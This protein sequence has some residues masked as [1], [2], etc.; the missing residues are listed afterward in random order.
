MF[1]FSHGLCLA[2]T[3]HTYK[4][5][6]AVCRRFRQ[7]HGCR[8]QQLRP[9]KSNYQLASAR[10]TPNEQCG[11]NSS[12]CFCRDFDNSHIIRFN[13]RTS[14]GREL[15]FITIEMTV[16]LSEKEIGIRGKCSSTA[17]PPKDTIKWII[18]HSKAW[19]E[20]NLFNSAGTNYF[21]FHV[22][23]RL[24]HSTLTCFGPY[25]CSGKWPHQIVYV[26]SDVARLSL[27]SGQCIEQ[28]RPLSVRFRIDTEHIYIRS[29]FDG[30]N[31][32]SSVAY[33]S[34]AWANSRFS[35]VCNICVVVSNGTHLAC[36]L[37][38]IIKY[39]LKTLIRVHLCKQQQRWLSA[40]AA[41]TNAPR[42]L[43]LGSTT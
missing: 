23:G 11:E 1:T 5:I 31:G 25:R 37:F 34:C 3:T 17:P 41:A 19:G 43:Q 14:F 38:D 40:A 10:Y 8:I 35:G 15:C 13:L 22:V 29:R 28:A 32:W 6:R 20:R 27:S 42:N 21:D 4:R 33:S 36:F 2:Q 7:V 39:S 30:K 26:L 9:G 16:W 24:G 18:T 12:I